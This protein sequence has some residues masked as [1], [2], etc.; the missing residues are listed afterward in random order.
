D[1]IFALTLGDSARDVVG[2]TD[3]VNNH[4]RI[5]EFGHISVLGNLDDLLESRLSDIQQE[6]T[7]TLLQRTS[8]TLYFEQ[9]SHD[10]LNVEG[11]EWYFLPATP[12]LGQTYKGTEVW[13]LILTIL[14]K[15]NL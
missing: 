2:V 15:L 12:L 10:E 6:V 7:E 1:D 13:I 9:V 14:N 4:D 5:G 8:F 11:L 3:R